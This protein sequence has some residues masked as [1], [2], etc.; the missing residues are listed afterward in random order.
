[1]R[2]GITRNS[3]VRTIERLV[4]TDDRQIKLDSAVF[5]NQTLGDART[6][7]SV[8]VT[9]QVTCLFLSQNACKELRIR[10][11][12]FPAQVASTGRVAECTTM[13]NKTDHVHGCNRT[14]K[15]EVPGLTEWNT[16]SHIADKRNSHPRWTMDFQKLIKAAC[17]K[18]TG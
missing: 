6:S 4:E 3:L 2:M 8:Y 12:D 13:N 14:T 15:S 10:P 11:L 5:L 16:P 18:L 9:P 17:A 1:M 7:N